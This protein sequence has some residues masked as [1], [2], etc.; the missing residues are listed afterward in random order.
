MARSSKRILELDIKRCFDRIDHRTMISRG[1][2]PQYIKTGLWKCLKAGTN[3]EFPDQGTPQGGV[4][5]PLLANIALDGIENIHPSVRYADDM[6]FFLKPGDDPEVILR[7]LSDFLAE[8][9]L[10]VKPEKTKVVA[11]TDGFD[12]LGWHFLVNPNGKFISTPSKENYQAFKSKVK[13]IVNNSNYGAKVKSRKLTPLIRGWRRYHQNCDMSKHSLWRMNH[14]TFQKF[15]QE[16]KQDQYSSAELV[17]KAFPTVRWKVNRHV[18]VKGD[19]SPYDGDTLYWSKRNSALY[20][21]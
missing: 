18:T 19:R 11:A 2:A 4:I 7:K 3:P 1:I 5:S 10:E 16:R 13:T 12:F 21:K 9:K 15:N 20:D 8:R 17:K 14:D 6:V